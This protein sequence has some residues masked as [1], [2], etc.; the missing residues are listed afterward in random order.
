MTEE[1]EMVGD[2]GIGLVGCV[3][4]SPPSTVKNLNRGVECESPSSPFSVLKNSYK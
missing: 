2:N 1:R 4:D 3:A